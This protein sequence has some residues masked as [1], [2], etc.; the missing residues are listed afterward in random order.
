MK[1][2]L[3]INAV[4]WGLAVGLVFLF[5]VISV[6][7]GVHVF[8]GVF[9]GIVLSLVLGFMLLV[10]GTTVLY[11]LRTLTLHWIDMQD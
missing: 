7:G 3:V 9:E 6:Y 4:K 1:L 2:D 10:S 5:G 8:L 11:L